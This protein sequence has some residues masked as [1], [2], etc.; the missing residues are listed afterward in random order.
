MDF[1]FSETQT[2]VADLAKKIFEQRL[3]PAALKAIDADP[4]HFDR[5]TWGELATTGLLGT[6]IPESYGG[7]G[8]GLMELFA[9]MQEAGAAVAPMPL[10]ATLVLGALPVTEF[11][12]D[13]Q[14]ARLL[15]RIVAGEAFLTTA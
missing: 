1:A 8:Q 13:E 14:R 2:A 3:T 4:A 6:A 5:K 7:S 12:S 11:G 10:W 9:L 15:P